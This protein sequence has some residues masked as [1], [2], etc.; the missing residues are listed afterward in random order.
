MSEQAT[1]NF[2]LNTDRVENAIVNEDAAN[3]ILQLE[4]WYQARIDRLREIGKSDVQELQV[5][6]VTTSDP[7]FIRGFKAG[8][9]VS[10]N[11]MGEF[12]IGFSE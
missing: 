12:P 2:E 11:V 4:T 1:P 9:L 5:G 6:D 10:I 8:L 7:Q 3:M